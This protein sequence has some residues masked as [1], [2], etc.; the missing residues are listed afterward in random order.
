MELEVATVRVEVA[1]PPAGRDTTAGFR[2]EVS[3]VGEVENREML[4]VKPP[5]LVRVI[6][7][8]TEDPATVVMLLGLAVI[9]KSGATP[10]VMVKA[11]LTE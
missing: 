1:E 8:V 5:V 3:P 2:V 9:V 7:E 4:P 11:T 6:V 10:V